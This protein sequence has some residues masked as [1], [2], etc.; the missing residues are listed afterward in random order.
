MKNRKRLAG[1]QKRLLDRS[2]EAYIL[3]LE[4]INRLAITY[5]VETFTYLICN[6]WELLLKTKITHDA[7]NS[8]AIYHPRKRGQPL[9]SFS[10]RKCLQEVFPNEDDPIRR[11]IEFV[12]ELRDEA[13]HLVIK[14]V[15]REVLGLFQA[16]VLNYH[17]QLQTWFGIAL[18]ERVTV[19]MM[20]IVYDLGPEQ[21]DLDNATFRRELGRD[22]AQYLSGFQ[23]RLR[24]ELALHGQS[25]ELAID[26][27]YHLVLT[28]KPGDADIVLTAGDTGGVTHVIEVPK[29]ASKTH[30][31]RRKE[32]VVEVNAKLDGAMRVNPYD[33]QCVMQVHNITKRAEFYFKSDIKGAP[34]QYSPE[35]VNWLVNQ[36]HKD[37]AFFQKMRA[38]A[39]KR[40]AEQPSL[41][42]LQRPAPLAPDALPTSPSQ[43]QAPVSAT[44]RTPVPIEADA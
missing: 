40:K 2:I 33:I 25:A 20:T 29:D 32:L 35:F 21:F 5:R 1:L 26:I 43:T 39:G 23:A 11:N 10:L 34:V 24:E 14:Q 42:K 16:C 6:A 9:R 37:A 4:T 27:R 28:K 41:T 12:A 8:R 30:P 3:S 38:K 15:S 36:Y 7:G 44:R 13:T 19:G 18:S 31:Y 22:T 17:R